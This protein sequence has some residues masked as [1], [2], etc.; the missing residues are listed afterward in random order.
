MK[1]PEINSIMQVGACQTELAYA[2]TCLATGQ[3]PEDEVH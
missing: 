1:S 3:V 2:R